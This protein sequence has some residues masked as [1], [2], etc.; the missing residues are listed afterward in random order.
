MQKILAVVIGFMIC[1]GISGLDPASAQKWSD[2][3]VG[4]LPDSSF[5]LIEFDKSNC[6]IRHLPYR[7]GNGSI[8]LDQLI[9]CLGTFSSEQWIDIKNRELARKTLEEHYYRFKLKK[10]E[11]GLKE[12]ININRAKLKELVL[13]PNIG[14]VTAVKIYNYRDNHGF[15]EKI[16]DI[17]NVEGIGPSTFN[18]IR[19]YITVK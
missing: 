18:G 5:A 3:I 11:E 9:Y 17:K 14:P 4:S 13:L 1:S 6:K 7:D 2:L 8:D 15:I 12:P 10:A 16:E 19:Y